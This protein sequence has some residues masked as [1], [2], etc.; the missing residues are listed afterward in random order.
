MLPS[1]RGE[2]CSFEDQGK[3][4]TRA[5]EFSASIVTVAPDIESYLIELVA[6][7]DLLWTR[8]NHQYCSCRKGVSLKN[9]FYTP[10]LGLAVWPTTLMIIEIYKILLVPY[11][12]NKR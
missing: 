1:L 11:N 2:F 12:Q 9:V 7:L 3:V 5:R 8:F 10:E 6:N 4:P